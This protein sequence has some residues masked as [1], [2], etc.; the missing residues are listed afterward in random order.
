MIHLKD[1]SYVRLGT[2]DLAGASR[3]VHDILGLQT[4]LRFGN[5]KNGQSVCFRSDA[6]EHT[7]AYFDGDPLDHTTGFELSTQA[8]L[9]AAAAQLQA[10]GYA[11]K[12]GSADECEQRRVKAF[13]AFKDP[14]GNAI[15]LVV[16]PF[17]SG[18]R[19]FPARDT[20]NTG[21]SHVGLRT[22]DA[23]RD[24]QF[25]TTVLSA[26]VSDRIGAAA[27]LRIDEVHHKIALFPSAHAGVQH[28]NHQ[29]Q[30]IDDLMRAWYFMQKHSVRVVFGPG[31]HPTSGAMFLYFEGPEGMVYEFSC[32]VRSV[33]DP[34][35][36]PRQ[37][38]FQP[39]SFCMWGSVPDI[40]EF[41]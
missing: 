33:T 12:E 17:H 6:R 30:S 28:I 40:A 37:F 8:E 13:A 1:I 15:E 29:V 10:L 22:T 38:P 36:I 32:G 19:F 3:Y 11:V 20:G 25:W 41:R 35:A 16:A 4:S 34:N 18:V 24:E 39:S 31:R 2:R 21:F 9:Q 23:A 5:P 7:L 27:L 26:K 14:S